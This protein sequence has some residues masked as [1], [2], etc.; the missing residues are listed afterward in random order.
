MEKRTVTPT[1]QEERSRIPAGALPTDRT[2]SLQPGERSRTV[3]G[4]VF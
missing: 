3:P 4:G 1:P 2:S